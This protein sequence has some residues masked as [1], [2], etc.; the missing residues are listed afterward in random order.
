MLHGG[1]CRAYEEGVRRVREVGGV[2]VVGEGAAGEEGKVR[3]RALVMKTSVE[4]LLV[5]RVLAEEVFGPA[6]LLVMG[7][8]AEELEDV[9]RSLEGHLTAT[10]HGTAEDVAA[11]GELIEILERKVGRLL[12]NGWPTGVEV[13][14]A[15]QHGGPYPATTDSHFTSVGTAAILR[16]ARPLC[17]QNWPQS[18]LPAELRDENPLGIWRMID[19]AM[20]KDRVTS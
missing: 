15:T 16:W 11:F 17:Y 1:I 9:A 20:T 7:A 13:G 19:G 5:N 4:N 2:E 6:T 14:Y 3:G 12:F 10:V 8:S 18:A